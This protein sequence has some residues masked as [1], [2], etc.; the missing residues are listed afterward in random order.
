MSLQ[1]QNS[2]SILN[3]N[4][5]A[6][7]VQR[8]VIFDTFRR[9]TSDKKQRIY[10]TTIH[11][12]GKF[13]YDGLSIDNFCKEAS[14]SKGSFFQYF[15]SKSHLLEFAI[16]IF[17][18]YIERLFFNIQRTEP[19]PLVRQKL[20]HLFK[21]L[22][23]NSYL[24]P[25]E[26]RFYFFITQALEHSGVTLHGINLERHIQDYIEEIIRRGEETGEI[27]GDFGVES[28]GYLVSLIIGAL[29]KNTFQET[30]LHN[31]ETER[32]LMSFLFDG[33]KA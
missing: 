29:V 31:S 3:E 8:G 24:Y 5:I 20:S 30:I 10:Q 33:I 25:A 27:R 21:A 15:S 26:K 14:I 17:D 13:G 9:L 22:I 7:L 12:F 32:Y 4:T 16:L 18:D 11:L 19:S 23:A 6:A 1:S 2:N 28:T